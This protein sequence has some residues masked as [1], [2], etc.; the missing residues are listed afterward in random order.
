MGNGSLNEFLHK[1][2]VPM[3]DEQ[4]TIRPVRLGFDWILLLITIG[5][6]I[7]GL[8][9]VYSASA[10]FSV[11]EFGNKYYTIER[12]ARL[13]LLGLLVMGVAAIFPYQLYR[14]L[15]FGFLIL[16]VLALGSLYFIGET[17]LGALRGG[18]GGS[19]QPSE[20]AKLV[21]IVYMSAWLFGHK[22]HINSF[23]LGI[24]PLGVALGVVLAL[25]YF[26]PDVS[27]SLT[28]LIIGVL[29]WFLG[30]GSFKQLLLVGAIAAVFGVFAIITVPSG[31]DRIANFWVGW[32]D[33]LKTSD[34][35][36]KG[37]AGFMRGGLLGTGIGEGEI[38][39]L[40]LPFPHTDSIFAVI[41]EETGL[42]GSIAL[43]L[44][45][46]G[47]LLRGTRIALNA[48]DGMGRLLA[49]GLTFWIL[50]EATLN[51][52]VMLGVMPFAG[53]A[54]PFISAGGSSMLVSLAAVGIMLNISRQSVAAE[55]KE[56]RSF[57][58]VVDL[59]GRNWRRRV[60]RPVHTASSNLRRQPD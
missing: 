30:G 7:F 27:A 3:P 20:L 41:G 60:S 45:Y 47:L 26:Q 37:L 35:V 29:M 46:V 43:L 51:M 52:L 40:G 6:V 49:G 18:Q 53:Q 12:Q 58:A 15:A 2:G 11:V 32:N 4:G 21:I 54:L 5:L 44:A 38:K 28:I 57:N 10:D 23:Q 22:E 36:Q 19:M 8:V 55:E 1:L 48:P 14:K 9:M 24:I 13:V 50:F 17:R 33:L 31:R 39:L 56:E 59:R 42:I 25:V 34:H 16:T